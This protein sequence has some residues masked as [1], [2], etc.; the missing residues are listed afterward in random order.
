M[1]SLPSIISEIEMFSG[2]GM[3]IVS[4]HN[5]IA[6]HPACTRHLGRSNRCKCKMCIVNGKVP[7]N[8]DVQGELGTGRFNTNGWGNDGMIS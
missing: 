3:I 2:D 8:V 5:D 7:M 4:I 6:K 1:T